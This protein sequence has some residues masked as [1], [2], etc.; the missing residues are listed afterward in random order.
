MKLG[1]L[2]YT[3]AEEDERRYLYWNPEGEHVT[4]TNVPTV[5]ETPGITRITPA[6]AL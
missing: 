6:A 4:A 2:V 5:K 3:L 1:D